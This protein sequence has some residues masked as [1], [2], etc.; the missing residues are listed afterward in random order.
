MSQFKI[1]LSAKRKTSSSGLTEWD[2]INSAIAFGE[3]PPW[4]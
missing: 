2:R 4:F 3:G 1:K